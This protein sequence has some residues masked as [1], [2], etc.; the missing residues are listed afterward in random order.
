[1]ADEYSATL[2]LPKTDF[3]MRANLP[4]RE[5]EILDSWE[6]KDLY[7]AIL[8]QK[9]RAKQYVLHDGPPFANG[10]IHMGHALNKILKDIVMK[11]KSMEGYAV[12]YIPGWDTHGLPIETQAIKKLK[13]KRDEISKAEFRKICEGFA[14]KYVD[15]Q[16]EQFKRLGILGDWEN[17]YLTLAPEFEAKQIRV[18]GEMVDK[19]YIY[20]GL[21]PVYWCTDCE[22]ALAEAE[23]EYG[24]KRSDS[25]Y[26]KF[27]VA[28]DKGI[29][30]ISDAK[31]VIWTT[32]TWTLPGNLLIALG[33]RFDYVVIKAGGEKLVMAKELADSVM[34]V[35]G[36]DEY[37]VL[38]ECK[39]TELAGVECKHPFLD[40]NS[41]VF[42]DDLVTL[43]AGTGCVH[44]APGHGAEDYHAGQKVG[45]QPIV[46]IE[47][48]GVLNDLAGPFAGQFYKKAN[49]TIKAHLEEI[50][51]LLGSVEID[52]QYPHCW[53]CSHPI[54]FRATEQW[55]ASVDS[56]REQALKA[57]SEV[58]W[59]P[60]WGEE[61]ISAMV[62]DRSDWC[63]S[64]QRLWGVPIPIFYC[65]DCN[66]PTMDKKVID[67]VAAIF[68]KKGSN[69]WF[70]MKAAD[71]LP[72]GYKCKCGGTKFRQEND[73]MDVWFDSG[74]SHSGVLEARGYE[75]PCDMYLEGN[76]QYRGWFQSSLLT[77]VAHTGKAPYKSVLTHGF[78]VDGEGRKMSKSLG[79]GI[80]PEDVIKQYG[81]DILR[82]WVA[83]SDYK[84]DIKISQDILKQMSE[85]YRKIRNT[86]RFILGNLGDFEV[87]MVDD[88]KAKG[89]TEIDEWALMRL[90]KLVEKVQGAYADYEYHVIYHAIHN[91]CTVDMSNFYLDIIKDRMYTEAKD[92]PT[93]RSAQVVMYTVLD[94][95]VRLLAPVLVFTAEEIWAAMPASDGREESVHMAGFPSVELGMVKDEKFEE[96]WEK[97]LAL[98]ED[99]AKALEDAR[100]E[101]LIGNALEAKVTLT[102]GKKQAKFMDEIRELME[103]VFI[104]SEVEL[105]KGGADDASVEIKVER[106]DGVKCP[107]CW[108][109]FKGDE[110]ELCERCAGVVAAIG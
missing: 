32:T 86:A 64:R 39:G 51:A 55:F 40:R 87:T 27:D 52:H 1:M 20:R 3:P 43:E 63:I 8:G 49:K 97:I 42:C 11:S 59:I 28:D 82:L 107:R 13:V 4:V 36:I 103:T 2:N 10:D 77:S 100:A 31:F 99:V 65:E 71:L 58:E 19:D 62:A 9:K 38:M 79:N 74:T 70:D 102:V 41:L 84:T 69:A 81:A 47:G 80:P 44:V 110:G 23:I 15:L 6:G 94:A 92:N 88:V 48:N 83:S 22:T 30:G 53:R 78:V 73:T 12:P 45:V 34:K 75:V 93:R 35:A 109:W 46:P 68:E 56:F 66:E 25:I 101:K 26:V 98:R 104:V 24:D 5:K 60:K 7:N 105:V 91:F 108:M 95:L 54:V 37:E 21:K 89:F 76:D 17:P 85:I 72:K 18:F 33:E 106:V 14:T 90:R 61:R 57:I 96:K 16:R 67:G 29:K 50:G